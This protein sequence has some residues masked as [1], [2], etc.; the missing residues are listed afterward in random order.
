MF[1]QSESQFEPQTTH[2]SKRMRISST[3]PRMSSQSSTRPRPPNCGFIQCNTRFCRIRRRTIG[4]FGKPLLE[5]CCFV[6]GSTRT[7][8]RGRRRIPLMWR[9]QFP[10]RPVVCLVRRLTQH[11]RRCQRGHSHISSAAIR[12]LR[13]RSAQGERGEN[14]FNQE[15][16]AVHGMTEFLRIFRTQES[17]VQQLEA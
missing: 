11:R 3:W 6:H 8:S 10:L 5:R 1:V 9:P 14:A 4:S 16:V 12:R 17:G 2:L 7:E 15:G 13:P